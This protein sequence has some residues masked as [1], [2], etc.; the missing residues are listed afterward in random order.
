MEATEAI[1]LGVCSYIIDDLMSRNTL[2][3]VATNSTD[4][5]KPEDFDSGRPEDVLF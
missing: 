3:S 2:T 5:G 1:R 4:L